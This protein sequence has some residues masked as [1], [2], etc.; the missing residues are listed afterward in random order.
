VRRDSLTVDVS[1]SAET[2]LHVSFMSV[3]SFSAK[4]DGVKTII[5]DTVSDDDQVSVRRIELVGN[6]AVGLS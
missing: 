1:C 6:V 2:L 4:G 5:F 3:V